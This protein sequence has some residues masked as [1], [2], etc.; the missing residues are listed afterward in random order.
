M[1]KFPTDDEDDFEI[2]DE[3]ENEDDSRTRKG[4]GPLGKAAAAVGGTLGTVTTGVASGIDAAASAVTGLISRV[5]SQNDQ[6]ESGAE[7]ERPAPPV[8]RVAAS[9][10]SRP[11]PAVESQR[12]KTTS[13]E[14]GP[15]TTPGATRVAANKRA[16]A[17]SRTAKKA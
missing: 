9:P 7:S 5:R 15:R 8:R 10:Q 13:S 4:D 6:Q 14:M 1:S 2:E 16:A 12:A 17:K 3:N 11:R